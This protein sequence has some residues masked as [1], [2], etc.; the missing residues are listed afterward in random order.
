MKANILAAAILLPF[1]VA[2]GGSDSGG[3]TDNGGGTDSGGGTDNGGGT[4][5]GGTDNGGGTDGGGTDGGGTDNGTGSECCL[6]E[7]RPRP[8]AGSSFTSTTGNASIV[9]TGSTGNAGS[10]PVRNTI[11]Q[12]NNFPRL[13]MTDFLWVNNAFNFGNSGY[14]DWFQEV[15]LEASGGGQIARLSYDWGNEDDLNNVND[16]VSFPEIIYGVKSADERSGSFAQTGLPVTNDELPATINID[17]DYSYQQG[18][19]GSTTPNTNIDFSGFNVAVESFWHESCDI[20]RTGA[21]DDNQ[22]FEMMVWLHL[23][24]RGPNS[25]GRNGSVG[26][27]TTSDGRAFDVF[28]KVSN[29]DPNYLAFVAQNETLTGTIPYHEFI[30]EVRTN[31]QAYGAGVRGLT[32]ED[33]L[34]NI[35]MGPEIW[36][37]AGT[38]SWNE[39]TI[40]RTY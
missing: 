17:Y 3:G 25:E 36:Y 4:D 22:V 37:G 40:T 6:A 27:F 20:K 12:P 8:A 7:E 19:S 24:K 30:E 33:C 9:S 31:A 28:N 35:L 26:T 14:S 1:L 34:A 13:A 23:G 16:T 39:V 29:G 32:D 21:A 10:G 11:D 38:F 18:V 2:C 5:G 15:S